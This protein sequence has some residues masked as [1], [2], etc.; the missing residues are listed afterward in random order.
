MLSRP[1][2]TVLISHGGKDSARTMH[3]FVF[4][5]LGTLAQFRLAGLCAP[6]SCL[7][8]WTRCG[9]TR[10]D[11]DEGHESTRMRDTSRLG[12]GDT[13]LNAT[14]DQC[15]NGKSISSIDTSQ[16]SIMHGAKT[17]SDLARPP[18]GDHLAARRSSP[19]RAGFITRSV[20]CSG[21]KTAKRAYPS[22]RD[23]A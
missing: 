18:R 11:T 23:T 3:Q 12:C 21:P 13:C 2:I 6:K 10:A 9:G 14:R 1:S 20:A 5:R 19:G 4:A 17:D 15:E 8:H 16:A 22:L 7:N